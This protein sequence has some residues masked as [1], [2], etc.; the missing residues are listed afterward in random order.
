MNKY[1]CTTCE[2]ESVIASH[3]LVLSD[4][5]CDKCKKP[6]T[7]RQLS[8]K[9]KET[10]KQGAIPSSKIIPPSIPLTPTTGKSQLD[11]KGGDV[12]VEQTVAPQTK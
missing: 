10:P 12:K 5:K 9:G 1:Y 2:T 3:Q 6:T 7:Y 8:L 11:V 4:C